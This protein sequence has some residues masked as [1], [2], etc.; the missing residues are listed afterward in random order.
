M[1][2]AFLS[3]FLIRSVLIQI[4]SNHIDLSKYRAARREAQFYQSFYLTLNHQLLTM[5]CFKRVS[6]EE[7][8]TTGRY[9]ILYTHYTASAIAIFINLHLVNEMRENN[10]RKCFCAHI[11]SNRRESKPN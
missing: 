7:E 6:V 1:I 10:N 5:Q 8:K 9:C 2:V 4:E 11:C 3:P